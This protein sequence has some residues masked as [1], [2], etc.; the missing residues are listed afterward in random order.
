MELDFYTQTR[1][2]KISINIFCYGIEIEDI[3]IKTRCDSKFKKKKS[4]KVYNTVHWKIKNKKIQNFFS[5]LIIFLPMKEA[6]FIV[7]QNNRLSYC[8]LLLLN[9]FQK[10]LLIHSRF[11]IKYFKIQAKERKFEILKF[12]LKIISQKPK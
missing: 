8:L 11:L 4:S 9:L 2:K 3:N 12:S 6:Y 1:L 5:S 7:R 10:I